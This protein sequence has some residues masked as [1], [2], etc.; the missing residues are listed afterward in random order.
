MLS[1]HEIATLMLIDNAHGHG[2]LDP[3]DLEALAGRQLV[4]LEQEA[5]QRHVRLT[6]QGRA[7]LTA[8]D[9]HR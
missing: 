9:K 8:I 6:T 2:E 7:M 5:G 1:P 4:Q 3:A